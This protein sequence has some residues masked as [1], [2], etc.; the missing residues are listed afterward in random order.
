M[1]RGVLLSAVA[2]VTRRKRLLLLCKED[3][4]A[5][6]TLFLPSSGLTLSQQVRAR[7]NLETFLS[8]QSSI[9]QNNGSTMCVQGAVSNL[10]G[11][12]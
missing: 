10:L 5:T 12:Y 11:E 2:S 7:A 1:S 8:C 9:V 4:T 3:V 6:H